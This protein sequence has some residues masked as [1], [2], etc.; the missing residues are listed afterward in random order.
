MSVRDTNKT[1]KNYNNNNNKFHI[2]ITS[3]DLSL[4]TRPRCR[5][6]SGHFVVASMCGVFSSLVLFFIKTVLSINSNAIGPY[7]MYCLT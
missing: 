1:V 4:F 6:D 7:V 2:A 3:G 5:Q